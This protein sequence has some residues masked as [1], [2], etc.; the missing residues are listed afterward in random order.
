[1]PNSRAKLETAVTNIRMANFL[2][3]DI[4][5]ANFFLQRTVVSIRLVQRCRPGKQLS[6]RFYERST[7]A[8]GRS[9]FDWAGDAARFRKAGHPQHGAISKAKPAEDVC[10]T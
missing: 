5:L 3:A 2:L 9:D 4:F 7:E 10:P 6:R 8:A 1:M